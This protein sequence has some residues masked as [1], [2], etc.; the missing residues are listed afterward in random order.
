MAVAARRALDS[1]T[2]T[3]ALR[4]DQRLVLNRYLLG[5]FGVER[6][7]TLAEGLKDPIHEGWDEENITQF[8]HLLTTRFPR[9]AELDPAGPSRD[10]LLRYD[11][12]IVRHTL[13]ISRGRPERVRWKYFQYLALLFAEVYLDRYFRNPDGLLTELNTQVAHFNDGVAAKDQIASYQLGDLRKLAFWMAT[14]SGKT[15]LMHVNVLQ[16]RHY[17]AAYDRLDAL[18]RTVLLTPNEG[19]TQ[20]HL[21]EFAHSGIEAERFDKAGGRLFTSSA[22]QVLDVHKLAEE[23]GEKTV[24]VDAFEG[25]NLVLVD[26]GHRGAGG[27]DW[28]DKRDRLA[29][30]GFSFEYSATF[31]QAVKAARKES[32][33]QEYAR[34]ILFDYSYRYFY[35]DG[36]GKD[37]QILNLPDGASEET[38]HLYLTASLLAFYQQQLLYADQSAAFLP[39]G[40]ERPLWVFVGS[41]VTAGLGRAEGSDV[42][43]ILRFLARFFREREESVSL[44][45]RLMS[46]DTGLVAG[47]RDVF[48]NK[49]PY[50]ADQRLGGADLYAGILR[51]FGNAGHAAQ[52][53]VE[54]L[55]GTDGELALRLGDYD[56]FGVINVGDARA[57]AKLCEAEP[58]LVVTSRQLSGSL[59]S[60]LNDPGSSVHLLI[61]S[62]KF[63]E[64]WNSYRVSSL[65]LMNVGRGEGAQIIQLFG[66]GVRLRGLHSGLQRSSALLEARHP[67]RI[68]LLETLNV[69]GLRA[70]Y[71]QRF[72][73]YLEEE[74]LPANEGLQEIILPVV[75]MLPDRRLKAIRVRAGSDFK[76]HAPRP[77]LG[78]P[79][80]DFVTRRVSLDYYPKLQALESAGLAGQTTSADVHQRSLSPEHLAFMD[81]DAVYY[82]LVR[83]KNE[84]GWH[85]MIVTRQIVSQLLADDDWYTLTI[86]E[87]AL[88]FDGPRPLRR[89]RLWEEIAAALLKKYAER[90][91]KTC[92]EA[93]EAPLREYYVL[94]E[95]DSNFIDTYR[96]QVEE[97]HGTLLVKLKQVKDEIEA[98]AFAG[99]RFPPLDIFAFS[100]HLYRPLVHISSKDIE[101]KPAALNV[102]ERDFVADLKGHYEA[103]PAFFVDKELYLLRNLTRGK[104]VGFF[105]AGNFYP[106]FILWLLVGNH[107]YVTFIDPK[108]IVRLE[109]VDDP[110][111]VFHRTIKEIEAALGD[112]DVTLNSFIV[113]N[114]R[115][116]DV[117]TWGHSKEEL[118]GHHVLFQKDDRARYIG[119]MLDMILNS[120]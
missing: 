3:P 50:L 32:L 101:V 54:E 67:D 25:N 22:I 112:P 29:A 60:G 43:S 108:G 24:A 23:M 49:Y 83:H 69:Y 9:L 58:T 72:K 52:L 56:P 13:T 41:S 65:G 47:N 21:E 39:Y 31:G 57:L 109:R 48:A 73:E 111:I 55:K 8:H 4:F 12:N 97:T 81:L 80:D 75:K 84:R 44:L 86:P 1:R 96:F 62:K 26:E 70:D 119:T 98:G 87:A 63:S 5:L 76:Q 36:Y 51:R 92:R 74:G 19:L 89:V 15:L 113:S 18:N 100:R 6:F 10:D 38:E 90:Y 61:G 17:L 114:T 78:L 115:Y 79:P 53:R 110:K 59:F 68:G 2:R 35:G 102:G 14:G 118:R 45:D 105:E 7:E 20:Q 104:G 64:G 46:G 42:L 106:D 88:S 34:C 120:H 95:S 93:F 91:Y 116:A 30:Q 33:T 28:K 107:Q 85:N 27:E 117:A 66:R 16:Y 103:N 99:L 77:T 71:M 82:E 11:A 40:L 37:Y 94:D